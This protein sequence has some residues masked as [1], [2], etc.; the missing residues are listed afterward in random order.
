MGD[1]DFDLDLLLI[2]GI[3]GAPGVVPTFVSCNDIKCLIRLF[4]D[5]ILIG[6]DKFGELFL[7]V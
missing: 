7:I 4:V 1:W 3:R 5:A 2:A 6:G